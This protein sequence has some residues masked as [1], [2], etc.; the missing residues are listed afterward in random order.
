MMTLRDRAKQFAPFDAMKGLDKALREREQI[1]ERAMQEVIYE[2]DLLM[3]E[4]TAAYRKKTEG[5]GKR[6]DDHEDQTIADPW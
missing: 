6:P 4:N 3:D 2:E 1:H 5:G